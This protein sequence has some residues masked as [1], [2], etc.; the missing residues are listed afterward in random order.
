MPV[1][2]VIVGEEVKSGS[3]WGA[4]VVLKWKAVGCVRQL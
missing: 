1:L 4:G 3:I 2:M